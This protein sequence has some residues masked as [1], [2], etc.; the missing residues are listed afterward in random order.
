ML[1]YITLGWK[2]LKIW[3]YT[4]IKIEVWLFPI[5]KYVTV[6]YIIMLTVQWQSGAVA[7]KLHKFEAF[8]M[9]DLVVTWKKN[10]CFVTGECYFIKYQ[11][12]LP[13]SYTVPI[14]L[15][16]AIFSKWSWSYPC[17]VFPVTRPHPFCLMCTKWYESNYVIFY[18][19]CLLSQLTFIWFCQFLK[20]PCFDNALIIIS[21]HFEV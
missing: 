2:F 13:I 18:D 7:W 5:T 15:I 17:F 16:G 4:Q 8:C 9:K 1:S 21:E 20:R 11:P 19:N 3:V 12:T 10:W 14:V 6:N